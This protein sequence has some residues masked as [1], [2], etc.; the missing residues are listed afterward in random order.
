ML[1]PIHEVVESNESLVILSMVFDSSR[2]T[3]CGNP[4]I[5]SPPT[6]ADF[7]IRAI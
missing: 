1:E 7:A 2:S 6:G 4:S 3:R 5:A